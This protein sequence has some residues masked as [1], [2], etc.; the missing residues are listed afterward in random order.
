MTGV[1]TDV[2]EVKKMFDVNVFGPM[3]MV[4]TFHPLLVKTQGT[5]TN[6]GSVGGI[7]PVRVVTVISGNIGTN[8]LQRSYYAPLAKEFEEHVQRVPNTT[9][10]D[11]Y[12]RRVVAQTLKSAPPA[13]FWVGDTT[14][15]VRFMD[16]FGF[17]TVWVSFHWCLLRN[18]SVTD[19]S[20]KDYIFWNIFNLGKL[21]KTT[22]KAKDREQ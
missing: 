1:D 13:W 15:I 6:I 7:V 9:H 21:K 3:R 18:E 4:R 17:R 10:R 5:I 12:A 8:I 16:V 11:V 22:Q 2:R 14:G 19:M 20:Q